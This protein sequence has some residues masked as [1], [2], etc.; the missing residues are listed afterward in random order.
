M[1]EQFDAQ[2]VRCSKCGKVLY[3]GMD[4]KPI[5]EI[6]KS[7]NGKC[8]QCGKALSPPGM[9]D[10]AVTAKETPE[11]TTKK[12]SRLWYLLPIFLNIIGGVIGYFIIRNRDRKFAERLLIIGIIMIVV[13]W[14]ASFVFA[15]IAYMYI[16]GIMGSKTGKLISILDASCSDGII[17]VVLSNEGTESIPIS[18]IT[19]FL[20][21]QET[22][23]SGCSGSVEPLSTVVCS[24]GNNLSGEQVLLISGPSNAARESVFC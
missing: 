24:L 17:N 8:P 1:E 14:I 21:Q 10:K 3:Q 5:D 20:N 11:K 19:F 18:S 7:Y 12:P 6:I 9:T 15:G 16:S 22:I 4:L 23:P 13:A 2:T